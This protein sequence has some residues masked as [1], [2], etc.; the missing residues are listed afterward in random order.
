MA[1]IIGNNIGAVEGGNPTGQAYATKVVRK[2]IV[3]GILNSGN[4]IS[5]FGNVLTGFN[6]AISNCIPFDIQSPFALGTKPRHL[7]I[8][9]VS[10]LTNDS[11][12]FGSTLGFLFIANTPNGVYGNTGNVLNGDNS[13]LNAYVTNKILPSAAPFNYWQTLNPNYR[14]CNLPV[15]QVVAKYGSNEITKVSLA[16]LLLDSVSIV[17]TANS[18]IQASIDYSFE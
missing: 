7:T 10:F 4:T 11:A 9:N 2:T 13:D 3:T 18:F 5:Q 14:I 8:N 12:I 16:V 6:N 17:T 1:F 15:N